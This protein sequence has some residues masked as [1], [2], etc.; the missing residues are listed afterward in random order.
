[1]AREKRISQNP[2]IAKDEL[3]AKLGFREM[4]DITKLLYNEGQIDGVPKNPRYLK[5]SEHDKLVKSLTDS[6][7]F[8]EYKP[9]M[10]YALEDGTY[11]TICGN[12]RLRVINELRIG[13][14]INFEKLPCFILKA[15]TPI[16]KI[17]EYAIK[18]NVQAGNWDWDELA[19]GEWETDDLQNWGVDC[20]FLNTDEDDTDIDKL[21]EDAQ[22][23]ESKAKDIKLSV[24]IPQELED[25]VDEI[26]EI[27][28]S[29]VS[30]YEGVEIK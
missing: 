14:N 10:V 4:I 25:K 29:A 28:K 11:V 30:E 7:E 5:E 8:L 18:D 2:V 19:N 6:P 20:S 26:K 21:F 1:M 9:L 16:Q 3:L 27:I 17:K 24:H 12:M 15:D 13:G 23:T 22:N